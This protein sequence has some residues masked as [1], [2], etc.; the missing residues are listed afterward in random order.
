MKSTSRV[1]SAVRSAARSPARSMIGPAVALMATCSSAATTWARLVLPTPGGPKRRTWSRASPRLRAA[2]MAT[3]RLATTWGWPDV[4]VE[5]LRPQRLVEA[6]VVVGRPAGD[7]AASPLS[8]RRPVAAR[9]AGGPR[10]GRRRPRPARGPPPAPPRGASSRGWPGRTAG[11]PSASA[12][13]VGA[14]A[15]GSPASSAGILSLSS[16]T[17]RS[18]VFLPTP[19]MRVR[20]ARSLPR[21]AATKSPTSMPERMPTASLGPTPATAIRRSKTSCSAAVRKPNR[22]SVSSRTWVWMRR[23]SS[24]PSSPSR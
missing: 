19:G 20:R 21:R 12:G 14:A 23:L 9:G 1:S 18:A 3:R 13:A 17:R 24:S 16:S 8:A 5:G 7:D 10:S 6:G 15:S 2:S 11:R 4:L 22:A